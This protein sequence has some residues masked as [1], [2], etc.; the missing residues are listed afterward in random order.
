MGNCSGALF[1]SIVEQTS[2]K[3]G[4]SLLM[5]TVIINNMTPDK[6]YSATFLIVG[7]MN[8]KGPTVVQR[9]QDFINTCLRQYSSEWKC[10]RDVY[11]VSYRPPGP[12]ILIFFSIWI[13]ISSF[14][15][16]IQL[17]MFWLEILILQQSKC[18]ML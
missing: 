10:F 8:I 15:H 14:G 4:Y 18:T 12:R 1:E 2:K 7:H 9:I 5:A 6:R 17:S 16:C 11:Y 3:Y 13:T